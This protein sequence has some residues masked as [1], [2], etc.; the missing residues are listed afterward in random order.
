MTLLHHIP[1]QAMVSE[2]DQ[3]SQI[4]GI[5]RVIR[6]NLDNYRLLYGIGIIWSSRVDMTYD[7]KNVI[8]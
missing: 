5:I 6:A 8:S 2:N 3:L 4:L 7:M 1:Y